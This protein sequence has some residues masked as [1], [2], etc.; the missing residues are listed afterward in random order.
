M[1]QKL[2]INKIYDENFTENKNDKIINLR[3]S[4][5]KCFSPSNRKALKSRFTEDNSRRFK[6]PMSVSIEKKYTKSK[7]GEIYPVY[8]KKTIYDD[9]SILLQPYIDE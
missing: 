9:G 8:H 5:Q 6:Y 4:G 1:E 2:K 7:Y 3:I